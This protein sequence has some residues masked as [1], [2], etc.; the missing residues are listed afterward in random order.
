MTAI[1]KLIA[2][3]AILLLSIGASYAQVSSATILVGELPDEIEETSGL[4]FHNGKLW[5]HNDSEGE[6]MLY[7]VDTATGEILERKTISGVTNIDW[8]DLA[9]DA[10][11]I[12]IGDFGAMNTN[13][14]IIRIK[15]EDLENP[16]LSV[17]ESRVI[18]FTY[19][20]PDYP[21]P[22]YSVT[23]TRFD[24]EA[25]IAKDDT[26]F[27][28]SKNWV[29]HQ[30]YLYA[31]PNKANYFHTITPVDTLQLDYLV[32]AADYDYQTNTVALL[33]YTYDVSGTLPE[34]RPYITLLRNFEDN[35][36][37]SGSVETT[38]L[39]AA[40][41]TDIIRYNQTEGIAFRDSSRLWITNEKYTRS[42][43]TLK[44]KL[45]ELAIENY[46]T[47]N[48]D[49]MPTFPEEPAPIVPD[50]TADVTEI[51]EGEQVHFTDLST[52][53]PTAWSWSFPGGTP[54]TSTEQNSTVRYNT[55]GT[56]SVS[57]TVSNDN[58][59]IS[60]TINNMII[61]HGTVTADFNADITAICEGQTVTFHSA[62]TNSTNIQWQFFGGT[63][64]FSTDPNPVV[65]YNTEGR[66]S[67]KLTAYN[68]VDSDRITKEDY[69]KVVGL[70]IAN[71]TSENTQAERGEIVSFTDLSENA[72][73][74]S[75]EFEGAIP[76]TSTEQNPQVIYYNA[77]TFPVK[78]TAYSEDSICS[79]FKRTNNYIII[80]KSDENLIE[81]I[82]LFP[83]PTSDIL[84]I[85]VPDGKD[86]KI[87]IIGADGKQV[88]MSQIG[89]GNGNIDVSNLVSGN[90]IASINVDGKVY[91]I[92][93]IKL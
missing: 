44:A 53:D 64:E 33:G 21:E 79:D 14:R 10:T 87:E 5:T 3:A 93:F 76:E 65:T 75:W 12:Y 57:L 62:A 18:N 50:F 70:V 73:Y 8:E 45:R 59:E 81:G 31:I 85:N 80:T 16:E 39:S 7:S 25:F 6:P 41:L 23:N 72:F 86:Y 19:G 1:Q 74:W 35:D 34:S 40:G 90:Y 29:D 20:N 91:K 13:P 49:E 24:C 54:S 82:E 2:A 88:Y 66:Y 17:I 61:V 22:D 27:L 52:Q 56:Y 77:G 63:P 30:T 36:F 46:V 26:L 60:K 89:N 69:I 67:V 15:I 71:F 37:F 48:D 55:P 38:E 42:I 4:I 43:I 92:N 9:K 28:F 84:N 58:C 83:N 51:I 47:V 68:E 11:Y 32:C 78:L